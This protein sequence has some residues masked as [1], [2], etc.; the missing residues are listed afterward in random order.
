MSQRWRFKGPRVWRWAYVFDVVISSD[1]LVGVQRFR[2]TDGEV[3][4]QAGAGPIVVIIEV[5]RLL[6]RGQINAERAAY[7]AEQTDVLVGEIEDYLRH[8]G[9]EGVTS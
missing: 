7:A 4:Y 9:P 2:D 6:T 5:V 3:T 8:N 1:V